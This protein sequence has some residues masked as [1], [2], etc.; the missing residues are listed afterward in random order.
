M[1]EGRWCIF[2]LNLRT[3]FLDQP[4]SLGENIVIMPS[5]IVYCSRVDA[6]KFGWTSMIPL[7]HLSFVQCEQEKFRPKERFKLI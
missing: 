3:N 4:F 6:K 1:G 2:S 5:Y 7:S